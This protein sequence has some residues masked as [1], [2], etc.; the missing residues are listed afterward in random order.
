M[1]ATRILERDSQKAHAASRCSTYRTETACC[2][3]G[4]MPPWQQLGSSSCCSA[5]KSV[6]K[7]FVLQQL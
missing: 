7:C 5:G 3:S 2:S 1:T 6:R 4:S